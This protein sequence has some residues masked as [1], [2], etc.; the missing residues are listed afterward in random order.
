[1]LA[2]WASILENLTAYSFTQKAGIPKP[3]KMRL[4]SD[5]RGLNPKRSRA[6]MKL[7]QIWTQRA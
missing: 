4:I 5:K 7:S 1:M 6:N 2:Y 3:A